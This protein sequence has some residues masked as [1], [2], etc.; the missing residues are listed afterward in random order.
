MRRVSPR[1]GVPILSLAALACGGRLDPSSEPSLPACRPV[2][3]DVSQW[4]TF[5]GDFGFSLRVPP[6]YASQEFRGIDSYVG[7]WRR[8]EARIGFDYGMYSNPLDAPSEEE[9]DKISE[10][11]TC[12]TVIGSETVR[13]VTLRR[14]GAY[15]ARAHWRPTPAHMGLT[16]SGGGPRR[17]DQAE[18]L[19]MLRT[20]ELRGR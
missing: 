10:Y 6:G 13:L 18:V 11:D 20:V 3:L 2:A 15:I 17:S 14:S 12:T 7:G 5:R 1:L 19:A 16:I 9:L 8:G 4:P